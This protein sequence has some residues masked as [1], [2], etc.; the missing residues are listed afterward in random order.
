MAGFMALLSYVYKTF[1]FLREDEECI[2]E[3]EDKWPEFDGINLKTCPGVRELLK[4]AW[5]THEGKDALAFRAAVKGMRQVV[6]QHY[7]N[8]ADL[9]EERL[10]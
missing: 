1:S 10:A 3:V 2:R 9:L 7:D 4:S 5:T 6:R 8:Y